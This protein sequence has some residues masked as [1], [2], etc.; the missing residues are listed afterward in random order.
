MVNFSEILKHAEE[1]EKQLKVLLDEIK[2]FKT[3][4]SNA[5]DLPHIF[6]SITVET[7][8]TILKDIKHEAIE[9]PQLPF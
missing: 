8:E 5:N 4:E 9:E 1:I 2:S 6:L 3:I 7:L